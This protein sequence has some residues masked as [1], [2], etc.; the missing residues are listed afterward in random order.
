MSK[1][2]YIDELNKKLSALDP[3]SN[4]KTYTKESDDETMW[5]PTLDSDGNAEII[6]R[7]M[8]PHPEEDTPIVRLFTHSF[9]GPGGWFIENCPKTHGEDAHC[10]VCA[11]R[12]PLWNSGREADK[13]IAMDRKRKVNFYGN[14]YII[15]EK[16]NPANEGKIFK[17]KFGKKV[18][19]LLMSQMNPKFE[20]DP[21]VNPFDLEE[22]GNMRLRIESKDIVI[23]GKK[24][25][26]PDYD[27]SKFDAPGPVLPK[28]AQRDA[29]I[30]LVH[31]LQPI[32]APEQF[33]SAKEYNERF[34]RATAGGTPVVEHDTDEDQISEP[35]VGKTA[36]PRKAPTIEV[37]DGEDGS[38][39]DRFR[40]LANED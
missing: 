15:K 2:N 3:A 31:K 22:G 20:S 32:I 33:K 4:K 19:D 11:S 36:A 9:K 35:L 18:F 21:K 26:V 29:L 38:E 27:A 10:P 25:R 39:I 34:L 7:W 28:A 40:A 24:V 30:Q 13:K 1:A 8:P 12:N 16:N 17:Y 37:D 5:K 23:D 14:V 6:L